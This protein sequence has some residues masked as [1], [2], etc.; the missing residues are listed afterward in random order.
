MI[1]HHVHT[2]QISLRQSNPLA[3]LESTKSVRTFLS[4]YQNIDVR[5]KIRL[6]AKGW[7]EEQNTLGDEGRAM[8]FGLS[9]TIDFGF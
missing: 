1:F 9:V 2:R 3:I 5:E 8:K 7:G 4:T 6:S